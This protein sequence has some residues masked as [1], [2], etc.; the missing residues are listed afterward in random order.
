MSHKSK[1]TS[2]SMYTRRDFVK[3]TA[4]AT[5]GMAALMG[6][7][8][9]AYAAPAE[10]LR[11]G[12]VGCGGRGKG[13][14]VNA[15]QAAEGVDLVAMGDLFQDRLDQA[16]KDLAT[17]T[18]AHY[19]VTDNTSFVGWDAY[20]K[21]IDSD[22]DYVI[23]ATPVVFRPEHFAYAVEKGKHVFMEKPVAVDPVGCRSIMAS[24]DVARQKNLAVVAG[25]QRRHQKR[26]IELMQRIHDGLMGE[27]V[28]GD[29]YW[30]QGGLWS[31]PR[32]PEWSDMEFQLR[33]WLYYTHLSGD[34]I[35]EQH[36]HQIDVANWVMQAHP[37]RAIGSGGRQV[38]TDPLYGNVYDHFTTIFEYPNGT[39][40]VSMCR[41]Q[42]GTDKRIEE[43]FIGTKGTASAADVR[44]AW[45]KGE[46]PWEFS[47]QE[48]NPYKQEHTD[49][50]E[51]IRSGAPINEAH[52]VAESVLT[53]L[54][55]REAAYTGLE[56]TWDQIANS[57]QD[58]TI[59]NWEFGP[60]EVPPVAAPGVTKLERTLLAAG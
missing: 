12:L 32:Q 37:I 45:M 44:W 5:A 53:A 35:V 27:I 57:N 39:K 3:T 23:L 47:G 20:K 26:Y 4:A 34:H 38:R 21:V 40:I 58:L 18:G 22:I 59:K 2:V 36:I 43:N 30:N 54:M 49:L 42:D 11:V 50:I 8:N 25:T 51:S 14:A 6:S 29:V 41:Q 55:G 19:K 1:R 13:A 31:H 15:V 28:G 33:N 16:K 60:I 24:G 48:T 10:T 56:I 46:N 7:T 9:F 17:Y 52:E